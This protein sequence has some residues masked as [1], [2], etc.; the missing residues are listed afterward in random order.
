MGCVISL[1][2]K[3]ERL[4]Y[5]DIEKKNIILLEELRIAKIRNEK[6]RLSV[7]RLSG[8]MDFYTREVIKHTYINDTY[9]KVMVTESN[10]SA[11]MI[12][13]GP[14]HLK[15]MDDETEKKYIRD[16]LRAS[17]DMINNR[18]CDVNSSG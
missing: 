11:D 5:Q 8:D 16:V 3:N 9:E 13:S 1:C 15:Y 17:Y 12:M 10:T 14:L 6:L 18:L 4:G 7:D 2:L